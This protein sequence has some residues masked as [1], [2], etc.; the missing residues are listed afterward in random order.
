MFFPS[1][2]GSLLMLFAGCATT[3]T[4]ENWD[5]ITFNAPMDTDGYILQ[6]PGLSSPLITYYDGATGQQV[7]KPWASLS[8]DQINKILSD[9]HATISVSQY[10]ASGTVS[11]E[12]A[13]ATASA[14][15]YQVIMNYC[16]F[17]GEDVQDPTTHALIGQGRVGVG[18]RLTA[19]IITT[20]ADIN[21]GS[22]LALGV[23]ADEGTVRG[24]MSV[25]SIG[26]RIA[27]NAGPILSNT[28]IDES[29]IQKTL[30]AIAVIQSKIADPTTYLDPQL[31]EIKPA[32]GQ[33]PD[34]IRHSLT[35][36]T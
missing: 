36:G 10:N 27:G 21:L 4:Q 7:T 32:P 1:F 14:G 17:V 24:T 12:A 28:T 2:A 11:Y 16:N 19:L 31:I 8:N 35:T 13:S 15:R 3:A 34:N 29:S 22:V 25:D 6:P 23:A 33:N 9:T 26:I 18:L 20:K 30:E 5:D